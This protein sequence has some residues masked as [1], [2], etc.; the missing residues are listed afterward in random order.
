MRK[1]AWV[2]SFKRDE[3]LLATN[4]SNAAI[5]S[6]TVHAVP[7]LTAMT[8]SWWLKKVTEMEPQDAFWPIWTLSPNV[9]WPPC[10]VKIRVQLC[11]NAGAGI[12]DVFWIH[13]LVQEFRCWFFETRHC[14]L[15]THFYP[16]RVGDMLKRVWPPAFPAAS[17]ENSSM[18]V[19]WM[20]VNHC[21]WQSSERLSCLLWRGP[22]FVTHSHERGLES[23][24]FTFEM[25]AQ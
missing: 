8:Q 17:F 2:R 16:H 1:Q 22:V 25:L 23:F 4:P 20:N 9:H 19:L 15:S 12:W 5:S 3:V 24:F 6:S 11:E 21:V 10:K 18:L 7:A 14:L 13:I